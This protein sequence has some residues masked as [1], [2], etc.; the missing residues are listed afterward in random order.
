MSHAAYSIGQRTPAINS[1][2]AGLACAIAL[3]LTAGPALAVTETERVEVHGRMVEAPVRY[4]VHT[5][6][7]DFD[8]QLQRRLEQAATRERV[9]SDVSVQYVIENGAVG[10][11]RARSNDGRLNHAVRAAVL[12]LSCGPQASADAQVY[13]FVVNFAEPGARTV[14]VQMADAR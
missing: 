13:R 12:S 8:A 9:A 4:D 3:T 7:A 2:F 10:S 6:C 14:N 1:L 11:V 5:T